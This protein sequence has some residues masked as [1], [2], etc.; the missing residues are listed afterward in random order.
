ML[1]G[2]G[3]ADKIAEQTRKAKDLLA[4]VDWDLELSLASYFAKVSMTRFN[5]YKTAG[6][7]PD[8]A[9][10]MTMSHNMSWTK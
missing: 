6:F 10:K 8:E 7:N 2:A 9:L 5:A 4:K 1:H 3:E